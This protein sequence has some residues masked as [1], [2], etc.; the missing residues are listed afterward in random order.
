[1]TRINRITIHGFKSFAHKTDIPFE[2]EFNCILGANGS[3]KS[4]IGDSLCFV[5][6]KLSA[7]SMRAEKA[8][9]LIFNGGK[10]KKP[11]DQGTVEI[12]FSNENKI[13]PLEEKEVVVSR[14]IKKDGGS[15][16]RVNGKKIT[17]TEILDLLSHAKINPD[18]YNII[19]QGDIT[20]FVT[21]SPL[22]RRKVIE[23]ISDVSLYEEKKHKAN[24]ELTKVEEKLNNADIILKE[25]K[26]Y[27][28]ELQKDRDQALKFKELRDK[29]D[30]NKATY[31]HLQITEKQKDNEKL[32]VEIKKHQE[33][34]DHSENQIKELKE[35]VESIK[36]EI[37]RINAEIEQKGEKEQVKV[38]RD[39]EE[40]K[41][42]IAK[43]KTRVST[44]K[45]E[46]N[47]IKLRKDQFRQEL[48]DLEQKFS[49]YNQKEKDLTQEMTKKQKELS[50]LEESI[51]QFK[52][53][54]KIDSSQELDQQME[55]KDKVIEQKQEEIQKVRQAQQELLR[56]K[57]KIEFQLE[58]IDERIRKVKE[59]SKENQEQIK[60]LQKIKND[61][62]AATLKLNK[63]LDN[64]SSFASQI[65]NARRKLVD[66]QEQHAK[67]QAKT[68]SRQASLANNQAVRNIIE[69]KK[70]FSGVHGTIAE[71]GKVQKK[72]SAALETAAG[73]R[74]QH[75]VVDDDKTA[76]S[77]IKYLQQNKLGSASFIPLNK[78]RYN[79]ISSDDKKLLREN[80]VHDFALS[81]ITFNPEFR[82]AF[83]YVF[84]NTL[85][86]EDI[87]TAR[88]V[89]I[90][91]IKMTTLDGSLAEAS[92]VM[93][94]GFQQ[95]R[96]G[97]FR[98]S[99]SEE[100]VE[101]LEAE[102][103]ELQSVIANLET[104][105][106]GNQL[107]ITSL[108]QMKGELEAEIIKLEKTLHL[109]TG[110]LEATANF[111]KELE[112]KLK[113][114]E[115]QLSGV[116]N[117]V[118]VINQDLAKVKS[119]KQI[120]RS[121]VSELRNPRL[122]AQMSAFEESR[123]KLREDILRLEGD[124]KNSGS[125][126][127][128]LLA[129][130]KDKIIEIIKQHDK[131]ETQFSEE[132]KKLSDSVGKKEEELKQKEKDSKEF[133]SKYKAL[134]NE[135]EKLGGEINKADNNIETLR[136][137]SRNSEREINL[138]SLKN[139]EIKAKLAGLQEE[140]IKYQNAHLLENKS[141]DELKK[142]IARFEV[143][144]GQMSAVNMK[145]LEIYE[146]IETEYNKLTDKRDSLSKEKTDVMTLMN[147]IE[148][149]K[150]DHFMKT[151]S[152]ANEHFTRIF[153]S[154]FKKGK[155]FLQLDNPN[156]PFEDG[157][158]IKVKISGNRYMDIKSL[159]GGE[160]TLTALSFIFAI[161]EYQPASF[162]I[163]DEIDA[164]LDKHNAETLAQLIRSYSKNAQYIVISH[165]DS[166]ISEADT[167]FGVS[168]ADG[169]SKVTSLKI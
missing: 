155:A 6:G 121:Q 33:K 115:K 31:I 41:V 83:S 73:G 148:T 141:I 52:K 87:E 54:N 59:V 153:S 136:E 78:I 143:M 45:D 72:Y 145:A 127:N 26:T 154:L 113:E 39:L 119:E 29:I 98:E 165:N 22:E 149:K 43:E 60:Q 120:L 99:D 8:S 21:M 48:K 104:K 163:L 66:A 97:G 3:G 159:S 110:D 12:A 169:I 147:E 5:L 82:K 166:L 167:L 11:A 25:R 140:F 150:K 80:G 70:R 36:T 1:M 13:F 126:V 85:V 142:E 130:E 146:Q 90:G 42:T 123:Q 125:Q 75:I 4:N 164:A 112:E 35:K 76:A 65:A 30:S 129:P 86:V 15:A 109:E 57:D 162:Y 23:E 116:Q 63:C 88:K 93:R 106:E 103:G 10:S 38:H 122:M 61:F 161:Q 28:K 74:M 47:K 94:G 46:I 124:L 105:R 132:I 14:T 100:L 135:R 51:A 84:G 128:Q 151:F 111:K 37:N 44:L 56:E 32:D 95:K 131:E 133:Y 67:A 158:S 144:L 7:K 19:L 81:V 24:L 50:V 53:K 134:F 79:D 40:L 108:R 89:G 101:K 17:R 102:V 157:L 58:S 20:R 77:C 34:I 168:M 2:G 62:K 49:S 156:N 160:K 107:E 118:S 91:R 137:K 64:D 68:L 139:A 138:V 114:V 16:Y 117:S 27:L 96:E 9:N 152:S 69:N 92:G 55:E 71:L 18:G